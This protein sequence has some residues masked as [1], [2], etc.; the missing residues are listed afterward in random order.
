MTDA[1]DRVVNHS[2]T[3]VRASVP[4]SFFDSL[5]MNPGQLS[6]FLETPIVLF[7]DQFVECVSM[8]SLSVIGGTW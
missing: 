4:R 2:Y 7:F 3:N 1:A 5:A 8:F 6:R